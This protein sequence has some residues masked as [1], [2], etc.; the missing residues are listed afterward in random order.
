MDII[1][2]EFDRYGQLHYLR[3]PEGESFNIGD[4]VLYP[5]SSGTEVAK[6]VWCGHSALTD[7]PLCPGRADQAAI[8]R[9]SENKAARAKAQSVATE[10]INQHGLPM[11]VVGVDLLDRSDEFD[12]MVAIYYTAPHRVDFRALVPDLARALAAR[13]D[14]RQVGARDAARLIGGVGRCGRQL[15]CANNL[16]LLEPISLREINYS[17]AMPAT[18]ACG[19]LLCCLRYEDDLPCGQDPNSCPA[20]PY[21]ND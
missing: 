4:D 13:I 6:V 10:L 1:G 21:A 20:S 16:G 18:G 17:T 5:T 14:L 9:D 12:R 7:I 2:V 3:V 19:R 11:R 8:S 15:C